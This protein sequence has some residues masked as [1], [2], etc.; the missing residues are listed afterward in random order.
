MHG[1]WIDE[2]HVFFQVAKLN[3]VCEKKAGYYLYHEGAF[4]LPQCHETVAQPYCLL[5]DVHAMAGLLPERPLK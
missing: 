4:I 2:L 3:P 1:M 5:G